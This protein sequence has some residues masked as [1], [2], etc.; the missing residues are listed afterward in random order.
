[1]YCRN[2]GTQIEDGSKF[3]SYCGTNLE[4]P[5]C[6]P[7][8]EQQPT[9]TQPVYQQPVYTQPPANN[10]PK[11]KKKMFYKTWWFWTIVIFW[12]VFIVPNVEFIEDPDATAISSTSGTGT[13]FSSTAALDERSKFIVDAQAGG[14]SEIT[15][16]NIYDL[17]KGK[18]LC[19]DIEFKRKSDVGNALYEISE[20]KY[21]LKVAADPD[22][23]YS[24]RCGSY[25]MYDGETVHYTVQDI[26][27]RDIGGNEA[28]YSV[29]AKEIVSSYLK[30][31]STAKFPF[32]TEFRMQRYGDIVAVSGYVDS[33][34]SFG[35]MIRTEWIVQ[36]RT[37]HNNLNSY[38]YQ[39]LYVRLGDQEA[40]EFIEFE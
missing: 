20:K 19:T 40:G 25:E 17:L 9:Y 28:Y 38:A 11:K 4:Q 22:G 7:T 10:P 21:S 8:V 36:F 35:A 6:P 3:C 31:P 27:M 24:V 32:L 1:M 23:I 15:A 29:I 26:A 2:C 30:A 5:V 14:L 13:T 18:L 34:N 33:Q 37:D 16:G 39:V 12:L